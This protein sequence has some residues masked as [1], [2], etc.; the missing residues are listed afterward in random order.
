[1]AELEGKLAAAQIELGILQRTLTPGHP[2]IARKQVEVSEMKREIGSFSVGTGGSEDYASLTVPFVDVPRLALEY[3]RLLRE[4]KIQETLFGLLTEQYEHAKIQEAKDTPT[5]QVLDV[6]QPPEK[7]SRPRRLILLALAAGFSVVFSMLY[8][9]LS[10]HL[11]RLRQE[12]PDE[13]QKVREDTS[14]LREDLVSGWRGIGRVFG[15][16]R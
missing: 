13:W 15:R 2:Q 9:S 10:D 6:A 12:R 1:A 14:Q 5:I 11:E 4:V 16:K 7:K 8:A 3:G